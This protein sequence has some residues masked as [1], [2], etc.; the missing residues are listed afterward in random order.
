MLNKKILA[1]AIAVALSSSAS[2]TIDLNESDAAM[3]G[4]LT[5]ATES[6]GSGD[7]S[8]GLLSVTNASNAL[9]LVSEVGFT[10]GTGESRF[11][12]FDLSNGEFGA[13]PVLTI[14]TAGNASASLSTGGD[15]ESFVI[16]EISSDQDIVS[17]DVVTLQSATFDVDP[18]ESVVVTYRLYE[19]G[20]GA[21]NELQASL[22]VT[23][24]AT[25]I[26]FDSANTG[27][28]TDANEIVATVASG[29]RLFD[30]S[31]DGAVSTTVATLAEIDVSDLVDAG[32]I[33]PDGTPF[34]VDD[35]IDV[36]SDLIITG[37][38]SSGTFT[39]S[40]SACGTAVSGA[41][42]VTLN[43]DE[44]E[45]TVVTAADLDTAALFFCLD[46]S[47][48][49]SDEIIE[50]GEYSVEIE[51]DEISDE[52]GE[53]VYDT[54]SIDIPFVTT[55]SEYNQRIYIVNNS[56]SDALYS[57]SFVAED[58]VTYDAGDVASGTAAANEVTLIIANDLVTI[59]GANRIAA[60]LD[61]ELTTDD[62][63][64]ATQIVNRNSG[65]TDTLVLSEN[66]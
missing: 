42:T 37:D 21:V 28:F 43:S 36:A 48:L 56:N 6:F 17:G 22:L 64:V 45:A 38:F 24:T 25:A 29:F 65:E 50:R 13:A 34:G 7:L 9:D 59:T 62:V 31:V 55:F 5:V 66:Q 1:A 16:F 23:E 41:A 47:G 51:E 18:D 54:T 10:V 19:T 61:V 12:R 30:T 33:N 52:A 4:T 49:P 8:G 14:A 20:A 35:L 57:F 27:D 2:A 44:D 58:G 15:G 60:I 11:V 39:V 46:V 3:V 63:A 32:T 40:E 53:V 26:E